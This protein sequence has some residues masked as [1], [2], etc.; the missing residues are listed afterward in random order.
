MIA[1]RVRLRVYVTLKADVLDPQG[2]AVQQALRALGFNAVHGVRVGKLIE[3]EL[4]RGEPAQLQAQAEAMCERLLRNPIIE[5][6]R[7]E[8]SGEP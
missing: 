5:D 2:E 7:Y 4:E 8:L 3:L 6:Y 1:D